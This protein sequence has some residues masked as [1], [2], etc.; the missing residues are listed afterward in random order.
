MTSPTVRSG[1]SVP[2][3][4][5]DQLSLRFKCLAQMEDAPLIE[6]VRRLLNIEL[7]LPPNDRRR[8]VIRRFQAWLQLEDSGLARVAE[9]FHR[10]TVELPPEERELIEDAERTALLDGLSYSDFRRLADSASYIRQ[11]WPESQRGD[12]APTPPSS[13]AMAL[14]LANLA[15]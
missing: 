6:A 8:R 4:A 13:L 9:A 3:F 11:R 12:A 10:V 15:A 7:D 1:L 5:T 2:G 14:A